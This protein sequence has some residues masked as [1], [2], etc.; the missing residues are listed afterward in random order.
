M[1]FIFLD[2]H[3][4]KNASNPY[5]DDLLYHCSTYQCPECA[6]QTEQLK[7][8]ESTTRIIFFPIRTEKEGVQIPFQVGPLINMIIHF[9]K[10][11]LSQ[12]KYFKNL[13]LYS[14]LPIEP[15]QQELNNDT[16]KKLHNLQFLEHNE[17]K[18]I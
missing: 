13:Y 9:P 17:A 6:I 18:I 11:D 12:V 16:V 2:I 10:I 3:M 1:V 5:I 15:P 4:N 8:Y 7:H 14:N